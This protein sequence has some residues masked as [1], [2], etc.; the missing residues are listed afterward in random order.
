MPVDV[1]LGLQWG[2]EGKG[3]VVDKI[4]DHYDYVARFQGGPNAGHT[5]VIDGVKYVLHQ[6]PSGIFR[7]KVVCIIGNGAVIN[8]IILQQEIEKLQDAGVEVKKRLILSDRAHV[9]LPTHHLI[10]KNHEEKRE[11]KSGE[12]K[13][14][15]TLR[16]I[17]P[18]YQDKSARIGLRLGE[19]IKKDFEARLESLFEYHLQFLPAELHLE[20]RK[21]MQAF[22]ESCQFLKSFRIESTENILHQALKD[23]KNILAE[24]AQGSLLDID[25]GAYPFVTSSNTTAG[26]VCTGLGVPPTSIRKIF[27]VFKAYA[28]RVGNGPFPTE[29]IN[30]EGE[31]LRE[32]GKEY[33][34]TTG[35]PRRCGWLDLPALKYAIAINGVTDLVITKLDIVNKMPEVKVCNSY[36]VENPETKT[37]YFTSNYVDD[38][39]LELTP[40]LTSLKPWADLVPNNQ[41]NI[42]DENLRSFIQYLNQELGVEVNFLSIGPGREDNILL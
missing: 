32:V 30:P 9:I 39:S 28:T 41:K 33:G 15:S 29:L 22:R 25:F 21:L 13:I 23:N 10:D 42:P 3:K 7:P 38:L 2:D 16:G 6:I 31:K 37:S 1:V 40:Q 17:S 24:G 5:L 12:Q 4:G 27:G 8:P 14:G 26:G 11:Q 34:A 35:R 18:T 36:L 20:A 19:L